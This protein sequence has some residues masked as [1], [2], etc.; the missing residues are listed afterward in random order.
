MFRYAVA[1]GRAARDI[2]TDL[3]GALKSRTVKHSAT[4]LDSSE[5][6]QLLRSIDAY[7]GS[8]VV[9][10]ALQL[11]PLLFV[12]PGELRTMQWDEIDW[13]KSRWE[14]PASKMKMREPHVVPLAN[15]SAEILKALRP[16]TGQGAFVFPSARKGGRPLSDNGVRT[17]LR[18]LGY[19]NEQITPHG[20][21]AMART[22]LDEELGFR[23]DYIEHQLAHEVKDPLGRAYNRTKHLDERIKMMQ[24]WA[25]YLDQLRRGR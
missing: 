18:S 1:T 14:I 10:A 9:R 24:G 16:L 21:R 3:T 23:I 11:S 22:L 19:T 20:F 13:Q 5:I 7:S 17:A 8:M 25:D 2:A 12:R 6:G 4:I 15:Q